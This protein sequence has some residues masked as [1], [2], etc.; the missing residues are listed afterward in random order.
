MDAWT[1]ILA[2]IVGRI[3]I[4]GFFVWSGIEKALNFPGFVDFFSAAKYPAP[5]WFA[6]GVIVFES[7]AGLALV[8]DYQSRPVALVLVLYVLLSA[9]LFFGPA[10]TIGLQLF[11][12]NMAILGGLLMVVAYR[13]LSGRKLK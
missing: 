1:S 13:P 7:L 6:L 10:T 12:Q 3:L 4:G 5:L 2:P 8:I 9:T 11:L